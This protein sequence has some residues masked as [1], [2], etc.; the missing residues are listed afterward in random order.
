MCNFASAMRRARLDAGLTQSELSQRSGVSEVAISSYELGTRTPRLPKLAALA[1]ALG[2]P[3]DEYVGRRVP[4]NCMD[5]PAL[6]SC[7]CEEQSDVA[8]RVPET[9]APPT[10]AVIWR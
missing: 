6:S 3:L 4:E 10:L 1:D 9:A 8:I 7:H 5:I 2:L